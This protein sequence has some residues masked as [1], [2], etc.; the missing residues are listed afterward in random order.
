MTTLRAEF[1][2]RSEEA[3]AFRLTVPVEIISA[4][5]S[6]AAPVPLSVTRAFA[7]GAPALLVTRPSTRAAPFASFTVFPAL[8]VFVAAT[9][10]GATLMLRSASRPSSCVITTS[11]VVPPSFR[12]AWSLPSYF[13]GSPH[14]R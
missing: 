1:D 13:S 8:S 7:T 12:C 14:R 11:A 9:V 2:R 4:R 10:S 6:V 5:V 3:F